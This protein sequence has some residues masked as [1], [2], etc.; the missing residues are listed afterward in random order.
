MSVFNGILTGREGEPPPS[1]YIHA[2]ARWMIRPLVKTSV[3]PNQITTVRLITGFIAAGMLGVGTPYWN[4]WGGV[5]FIV[6]SVLD[7]A[8]GELA[9]IANR[10]SRAGH[11][12]DLASDAICNA[13]AFI[14]IGVA[15]RHQSSWAIALG[16]SAGLG[17]GAIFGLIAMIENVRKDG[18]QVFSGKAGIDPDDGLLLLGPLAWLGPTVLWWLLVAASVG[19]PAFALWTAWSERAL[20]SRKPPTKEERNENHG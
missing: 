9:R 14:G 19:A 4:F 6:S 3:Q 15:F 5:M 10:K 20:L 2:V 12:Y 13:A 7:R 1:T 18:Q 17:I 11:I 8:D 16:L